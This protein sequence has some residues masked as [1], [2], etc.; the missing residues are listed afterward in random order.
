MKLGKEDALMASL[1]NHNFEHG[2]LISKIILLTE[3]A[4]AAVGILIWANRCTF[5]SHIIH[6]KAMLSEGLLEAFL[7]AIFSCHLLYLAL[8]FQIRVGFGDYSV[9]LKALFTAITLVHFGGLEHVRRE[10][11][12]C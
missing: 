6:I 3:K 10:S 7:L 9:L 1:L 8:V 4:G 12:M 5:G 11:C 2:D